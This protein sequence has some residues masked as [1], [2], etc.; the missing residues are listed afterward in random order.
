MGDNR[1]MSGP[2]AALIAFLAVV[3]IF[4]VVRFEV[5]C[6]RELAKADD[7]QLLHLTRRG[8]TVAIFFSIPFGG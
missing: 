2:A 3:V 1:A 5:F 7:Y 4:V 6:L 8:W